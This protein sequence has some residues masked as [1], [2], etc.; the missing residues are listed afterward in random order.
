M[1]NA[2]NYALTPG[3]AH[4]FT[5]GSDETMKQNVNV[6]SNQYDVNTFLRNEKI[7]KAVSS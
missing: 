6:V 3:V 7:L 4:E 1:I 5:P 2:D